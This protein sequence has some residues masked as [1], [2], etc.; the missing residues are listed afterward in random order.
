[1]YIFL[2]NLFEIQGKDTKVKEILGESQKISDNHGNTSQLHKLLYKE[3]SNVIKMQF[4]RDKLSILNYFYSFDIV[5][6]DF[7]KLIRC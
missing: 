1:M 5:S 2:K 4:K 3:N 7:Q 6:A